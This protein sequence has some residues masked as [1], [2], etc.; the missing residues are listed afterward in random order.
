VLACVA[1][2]LWYADHIRLVDDTARGRHLDAA[3]S[4]WVAK[5]ALLQE[6]QASTL[7]ERQNEKYRWLYVERT[8]WHGPRTS[9]TR[10]SGE[11]K[12]FASTNG[13]GFRKERGA[14]GTAVFE[15]DYPDGRE[16]VRITLGRQVFVAIIIDDIGYKMDIAQRLAALPCKLTMSVMP[17]TPHARAAAALAV[18]NGKQVFVHMPMEP[19]YKMAKVPEYSIAI[20]RGQAR[21]MVMANVRKGL[22]V[23]PGAVGLNNHEGS[24]GT[25]DRA[26]MDAVMVVLKERNLMFVDSW[27]TGKTTGYQAAKAAGLRWARRN[28]FLD[29]VQTPDGV[30]RAFDRLVYLARQW[31]RATAI[32]HPKK[33][34]VDML[35]RRVPAA[36]AE[37]VKF[38][39]VTALA[40]R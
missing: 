14:A 38:V 20:L 34:T 25:E 29:V 26:L 13:L 10:L 22:A 1:M 32:G 35:E 36:Q 9:R 27:T 5:N 16:A 2:V 3:L 11:L 18:A 28:V 6:D 40:R 7:V 8:L 37:G 12:A 19:N 33:V 15:M 21:E 17:F 4:G 24:V 31:G 39:F 30:N 23:V